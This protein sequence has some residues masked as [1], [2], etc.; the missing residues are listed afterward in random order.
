MA[1]TQQHMNGNV[2][3]AMDTETT[4]LTAG[5]NEMIQFAAV[6]LDSNFNPR[7]D[8]NPFVIE[9]QPRYPENLDETLR[10][11]PSYIERIHHATIHGID[12]DKA[13]DMFADWYANIGIQL[14]SY[15]NPCKAIP[16][17]QNYQFDLGFIKHWL[18]G[19]RNYEQYFDYHY[20]DTMC[21]AL[22]LNDRAAL[23]NER[24]PFPKVSLQYLSTTLGVVNRAPHTALGDAVCTAEVY[25]KLVAY[26]VGLI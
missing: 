13:V 1:V 14:N 17:G 15:G 18:G 25:K 7:A 11:K 6:V 23:K 2:V 22:G 4:G 12:Q 8:I 24:I 10:D 19:I 26:N 20:R 9:L 21:L 3:I 5:H 16:L